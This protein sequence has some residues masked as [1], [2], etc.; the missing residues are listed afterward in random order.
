MVY[1]DLTERATGI[2]YATLKHRLGG[3]LEIYEKFVGVDPLIEPMKIYPAVHYSMG[4][5]WVDF[6]KDTRPLDQG[7]GGCLHG[8]PRNHT[9]NIPGLYAAGEADYQYHGANRLGANSLLSCIYTGLFIGPCVKSY[10]T[11]SQQPDAPA[12]LFDAAAKQQ[13]KRHEQLMASSGDQNP[14]VI[15]RELGRSMSDNVTIIRVNKRMK[16]TLA[17]IEDLKDR[18]THRLGMPDGSTWSNQSL[19]FARAVWDMLLLAE[20][21]TKAATARDESRGAHFKVPDDKADRHDIPLDQRALP[22]DDENWLKT[23][24]VTYQNNHAQLT[25]EPVDISLV[26]PRPRTYGKTTAPAPE[27]A[28]PKPEPVA[29]K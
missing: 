7:G 23:T 13:Q 5:L 22:R 21:I 24:I 25:Y 2:P 11:D 1:L 18:Y 29:A 16:Q 28:A 17:L 12:S 10:I 27:A 20:A 3:I 14:Y 15:H 8:D 19:A 4:G 9:T 26:K 6:A